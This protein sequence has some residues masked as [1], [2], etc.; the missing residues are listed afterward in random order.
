MI[1]S[2]ALKAPASLNASKIAT[3]SVAVVPVSFNAS[4][5]VCNS[6]PGSKTKARAGCSSTSISVSCAVVAV[7]PATVAD[8]P[9]TVPV[10]QIKALYLLEFFY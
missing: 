5:N 8:V 4:T 9:T 3:I 6:I 7:V 1:I 2:S 10:P